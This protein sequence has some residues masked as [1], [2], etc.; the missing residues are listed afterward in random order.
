[1]PAPPVDFG[2][3]FKFSGIE[4]HIDLRYRLFGKVCCFYFQGL[5]IPRTTSAIKNE[6]A[7]SV[8]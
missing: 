6:E 1:V 8:F 4:R 5:G 2:K 3:I 7:G